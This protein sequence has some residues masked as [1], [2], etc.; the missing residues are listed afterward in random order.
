MIEYWPVEHKPM[1]PPPPHADARHWHIGIDRE[2]FDRLQG[3]YADRWGCPMAGVDASGEVVL[4]LCPCEGSPGPRCRDA[5]A[6]AVW[7]AWRWGEP[8]VGF[9]PAMRLLLAVPL[10]YNERVLGGLVVSFAEGQVF[11]RADAPCGLD[12]RQASVELRRLAERENLTNA[13]ALQVRRWEYHQEQQRAYALHDF[14]SQSHHSIRELYLREEPAMFSAIRAGDRPQAREILNR[15]L[16]AIHHYA[17]DRL[18]LIKSF[19]L[20]LVV[21][22]VRTAVDVGVGPEELLGSNWTSMTR[23]AQIDT[24]EDLAAWLTVTLERMMDAIEHHRRRDVSVQL[25]DAIAYMERHCCE[26]IGRDDAAAAAHL[27]PSY[28]SQLLRRESGVTFTDLLNRMRVDRA[29]ERVAAGD[30]PLSTI[31]LDCGFSDQSYFT[32]VFRRYRGVTP[33]EYRIRRNGRSTA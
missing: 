26:S 22:M 5:R 3:Q 24:E 9:C 31:A 28:F 15:I 11:T 2:T 25:M 21:T 19:F 17:G 27:S 16:V 6:T 33:R 20:E 7:E 4:G 18:A 13:S 8:T 29:A 23:L 14:K 12:L 1:T 30:E 32:K 10:M